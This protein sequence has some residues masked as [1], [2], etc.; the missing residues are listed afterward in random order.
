MKIISS[1]NQNQNKNT[2]NFTAIRIVKTTPEQFLKF[3]NEFADFCSQ[4]IVFRAE[5]IEQSN[6]FNH[7][8]QLAKKE[9]W[10]LEWLFNNAIQ[11]KLLKRDFSEN[12]PMCVFT[13]KD[14]FKLVLYTLKHTFS[15][16]IAG[17]K[18]T[19]RASTEGNIP[20]HLCPARGLKEVADIDIPRFKKF[21]DKRKAEYMSFDEFVNEVKAG[22]I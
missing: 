6:F 10:P 13:G 20:L 9:N 17:S 3:Q 12:L 2:P 1:Y 15:N 14:K 19:S 7:L 4:N 16:I 18:A 21:M 11:F 22:K 8:K 5:S